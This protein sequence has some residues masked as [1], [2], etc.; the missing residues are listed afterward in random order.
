MSRPIVYYD[1]TC[2]LCQKSIA[3]LQKIDKKTRFDYAPLDNGADADT[4]IL[5]ESEREWVYGKA[6]FRLFWLLGGWWK[7]VGLLHFV[8]K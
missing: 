7:A 3:T 1:A 5:K 4:F 6:F 8:P 2:P